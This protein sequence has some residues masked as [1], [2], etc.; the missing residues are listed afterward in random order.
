M[1]F[2]KKFVPLRELVSL[3]GKKALITGG[4]MGIGYAIARRLS[5]AGAAAGIVDCNEE[6]GRQSVRE[7]EAAG[8]QSCFFRCDVS[9][10][11]EVSQTVKS[12]INMMGAVD[13]LVNNAGVFPSTPIDSLT[14]GDIERVFS[15]NLKG[16]LYFA[17]EVSRCMIE[18]KRSGCIINLASIDALH[19]SHKTF[20]VY[21]ASKGAVLSLTRSLARELGPSGIRVNAIAPGGILTEGA[22]N[23]RSAENS[24][25]A[26]R[27]F[28]SRIPLGKMGM[29]DDIGRA[30]LF[31]AS[32]LSAYMTGSLVVVDGGYLLS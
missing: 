15:V 9:R 18:Q 5:E 12:A 10:E 29:A 17:R 19:P 25:T 2:D 23:L 7:L 6:K 1:T 28:M 21:D 8:C 4:A 24:R 30:A 3:A 16:T 31:L 32:D 20:S 13:I 26:L 14:A 22:M 27:E 11:E